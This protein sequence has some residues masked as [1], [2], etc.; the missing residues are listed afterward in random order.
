MGFMKGIKRM[1]VMFLIF[2]IG[3]AVAQRLAVYAPILYYL[4][5]I[6]GIAMAFA[7]LVMAEPGS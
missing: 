5:V 3:I 7:Y 4:F 1:G 2:I 6:I